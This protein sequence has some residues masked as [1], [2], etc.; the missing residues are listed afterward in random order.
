L[1]IA[2]QRKLNPYAQDW[3]FGIEQQ[4]GSK[5]IATAEYVGNKG[6]HLNIRVNA[7]QP[8]QC[9]LAVGCD[10][11]L[12]ANQ[13]LAGRVSRRQYKNFGQMIIEDWS[14]YS[15]YNA[16]NLK[17]QRKA[18]DLTA[19]IGYSWSKM[20]DIKSAAAAVTG[21][22]GGAY[23][24]QNFYCP[25]CDYARSAYDV[26]QRVVANFLYNL[27]FGEGQAIGAN[28]NVV[29]RTLISG[30]Q[31]NGIGSV[32]AGFPF[33]LSATDVGN[34]VNEATSLRADSV[35]NPYPS[36]FV[37]N[38]NHWFDQTAFVTPLAGNFGNTSR[39]LLRGP[40]IA[41]LDASIF[42]TT[43]LERFEIQLRFESFNALNHPV[44]AGPNASVTVAR[45]QTIP[46]N[47]TLGTITSTNGKVPARENQA[48]IRITF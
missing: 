38:T 46:T 8:T 37:K 44:F 16:L 31:I 11:T 6:T 27:P 7:N 33:S 28:S 3:S 32:Q 4:I 13:S 42:K 15:N 48:A 40:G 1:Q 12:A 34:G 19:T 39:D 22:A 17:L 45:G 21:D 41:T 9:T 35:G 10:P 26:G 24:F 25:R 18:K 36:G 30:W 47:Y 5:T 23:G 43:K 2:A 29:T 14:G 20:M